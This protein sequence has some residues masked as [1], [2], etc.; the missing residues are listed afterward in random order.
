MA[1]DAVEA[2]AIAKEMGGKSVVK[3]Q[4]H[5]GGRGKGGGVKF[6]KTPDEAAE[7][8]TKHDGH[9]TSSPS[10]P[11][12]RAARS[13]TVF[14]SDPVDIAREL[15]LSFLV[16]RATGRVTA[17]ASTEG[18]VEIEE[19]AAHTPEK[20]VKVAV[21]PAIGLAG[22][23]ARELAFALGLRATASRRA[24]SSSRTCTGSSW[25]RTAP[26]WR[27]TPW[28]SPTQGDVLALDAKIS[29]DDNA[30]FRHPEIVAYRDLNEEA[31]AEID[32]S[33]F[34]LNFIKLDGSIG[35][36]VNGAGPGHGHHG[37]H[38]AP[39]LQPRQLPGRRRR[40]LGGGR[41]ERLPHHPPGP[42][43]QGRAGEHL[44]RDHALRHRGR[45]RGQR[46]QG[47]RRHRCPW[48]CAWR[49][50]TSRRASASSPRAA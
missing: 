35:C 17:L 42:R 14:L 30:L 18:G 16:D 25:R 4:I 46:R 29:F 12:P 10:R 37:H 6:A 33:K 47:D 48:W 43:R 23:Q 15:Y 21:D 28:W 34:G 9:D 50:P 36:M 44:R 32:A 27:S 26:W 24:W 38:P 45:R 3:A 49:A 20:I 40:R 2:A 13:S 41:E 19:V 5:A 7:L 8:F 11:A 22:H 1:Q 39:R 31:E